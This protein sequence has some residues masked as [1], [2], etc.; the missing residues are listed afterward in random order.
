[1]LNGVFFILLGNE[2]FFSYIKML[3]MVVWLV[4]FFKIIYLLVGVFSC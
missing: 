2:D 1:M 4:L 3:S